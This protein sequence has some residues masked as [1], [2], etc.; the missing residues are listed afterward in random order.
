MV[1]VSCRQSNAVSVVEARPYAVV[2][3]GDTIPFTQLGQ[4][5]GDRLIV[6]KDFDMKG[7]LS[8]LPKGVMLCFKGGVIRNGALEGDDTKIEGRGTMF[9][10]VAIK[11]I[12]N[13]PKISTK[14]FSDLSYE[15]ALRDVVALA[16][17]KVQNRITIEKGDY[18]VKSERNGD[19]GLLLCSNTKLELKDTIRLVPNDYKHYY[20]VRATGE[21]IHIGGN[22]CIIGDKPVHL[23]A[24]GQW[25]MGISIMGAVNASVKDL[26]IKECWGDCIYIGGRS[27]NVL[28]EN[29]KLDNGRRQG[30][31]VTKADGV[32]IK[33]CLIKNVSGTNPQYAIDIEP[34]RRD[35]VDNILIENV[36]VLDCMGGIKATRGVP[37]DGAITPWLG[38]VT[39]KN[40]RVSCKTRF[41]IS[42]RRCE[43]AIVNNCIL[44]WARG[45]TAMVFLEVGEAIAEDNMFI[46]KG[47]LYETIRQYVKES[48]GRD[49]GKLIRI[50]AVRKKSFKNNII[51]GL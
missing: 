30:V 8:K 19:V 7:A 31:S 34:N 26:T 16:S 48:T 11:G 29:C 4:L 41:P 44:S 50:D 38:R 12:W 3:S 32:T 20:I 5:N 37:K 45:K 23:G 2:L 47:N 27:K 42:M 18:W 49:A 28:I 43:S 17:P 1:S 21:N 25:G 39:I 14:M 10:K 36:T 51:K 15:N 46:P 33:K 6:N 13:V 40:C 9:D 35:S 24:E 22:G